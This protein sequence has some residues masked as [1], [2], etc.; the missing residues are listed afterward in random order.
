[1]ESKFVEQRY[2]SDGVQ[3]GKS[4]LN[5]KLAQVKLIAGRSNPKLAQEIA[6][7]IGIKPIKCKIIDFANKEIY[8]EIEESIRGHDVYFIQTGS[9]NQNSINDYFVEALQVA[10]ACRRCDA[11]SISIVYT[12]F[13]YAR[14]DKKDKPRVAIMS[15]VIANMLI[16]SGYS[17][18]IT[19]DIHSGQSQ[20]FID[21]PFDNLYA[22]N[23]HIENLRKTIFKD[24]D[25][26]N[27]EFILVAPDMGSSKRIRAYAEKLQISHAVMEKQRD[28]SKP[29]TVSK[30]VLMADEAVVRGKTAI[31]I[32]D[33]ADSF[34]TMIAA[35]NDLLTHGIINVIVIVTHGIFSGQAIERI[36]NCKE[37]IAVIVTDT[38][39]QTEHMKACSKISVVPT[40]AVFGEV[41]TR[42]ILGGSIATMFD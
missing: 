28:Y 15:S 11:K 38:V 40:A 19:M 30:S 9:S 10:D 21:K 36:N 16:A 42:I 6:D 27:E 4:V 26:I 23:I 17:R 24:C 31:V 14:S 2:R 41:I 8:V 18:I 5:P 34:G 25:K 32:D 12:L 13:P 35:V 22:K 39:D 29:G 33:I 20:G 1:M 7:Y 37:L 3:W